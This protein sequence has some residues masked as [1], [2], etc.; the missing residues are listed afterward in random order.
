[1][2]LRRWDC[3]KD[4]GLTTHCIGRGWPK[5]A[6]VR[7]P[8]SFWE[9]FNVYVPI[10]RLL[11][12]Y[13]HLNMEPEPIF[14]LSLA[15]INKRIRKITKKNSENRWITIME[16]YYAKELLRAHEWQN[17]VAC[18][19]MPVFSEQCCQRRKHL[20]TMGFENDLVWTAEK[21]TMKHIT[22][23]SSAPPIFKNRFLGLSD[24][25][26]TLTSIL[27]SY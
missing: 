5:T 23:G 26:D 21:E 14:P 17:T 3:G 1:M 25:I 13:M 15:N 19:I 2:R 6:N 4:A 12:R 10:K 7:Q 18:F 11:T 8:N 22:Y 24:I 27:L 16:C 20:H 9:I